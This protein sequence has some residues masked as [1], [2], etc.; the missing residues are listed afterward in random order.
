M[1][2]LIT[3]IK[4]CMT[5][6]GFWPKCHRSVYCKRVHWPVSLPFGG[7]LLPHTH[8]FHSFHLSISSLFPISISSSFLAFSFFYILF[9]RSRLLSWCLLVCG[10]RHYDRPDAGW[11]IIL[12][13]SHRHLVF[14]HAA[15]Y[16]CLVRLIRFC[17][18][19]E[20]SHFSL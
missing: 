14:V 10:S 11:L 1:S 17:V 8:T 19:T 18:A 15:Q 12:E 9:F 5:F 7:P 13:V 2:Y 6:S 3:N 4:K 20:Y 16:N